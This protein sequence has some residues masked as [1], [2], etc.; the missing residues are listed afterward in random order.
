MRMP[1][2]DQPCPAAACSAL[3]VQNPQKFRQHCT[4]PHS[5]PAAA[6][7][8]PVTLG[9]LREA[10]QESDLLRNRLIQAEGRA[11][12]LLQDNIL[13]KQQL[14]LPVEAEQA[15]LAAWT[16]AALP[17]TAAAGTPQQGLPELPAA[18]EEGG[19]GAAA[20]GTGA[21]QGAG[22]ASPSEGALEEQQEQQGKSDTE[23][24]GTPVTDATPG[25]AAQSATQAGARRRRSGRA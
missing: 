24:E 5:Q 1:G 12:A 4:M 14:G 20:A 9:L 17:P 16:G 15:A 7:D 13:L 2:D 19:S 21:S 10:Q 11:V 23:E 3:A 6:A 8:D 18:G 22:P 25:S